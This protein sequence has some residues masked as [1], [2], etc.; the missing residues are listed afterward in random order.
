MWS[1][2]DLSPFVVVAVAAA[3]AA[4]AAK[5]LCCSPILLG[6]FARAE[7]DPFKIGLLGDR[8]VEDESI[9]FVMTLAVAEP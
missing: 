5:T 2:F 4:A 7:I 6:A 8:V 3:A 9:E 1:L